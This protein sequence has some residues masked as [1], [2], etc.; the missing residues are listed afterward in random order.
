MPISITFTAESTAEL[1]KAIA[2]FIGATPSKAES[3]PAAAKPAPKAETAPTP[4]PEPEAESTGEVTDADL[5]TAAVS[6]QQK[7]GRDALAAA[8][9]DHGAPAGVTSIPAE[10]R[11]DFVAF[12][13]AE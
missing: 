10:R 12:C 1:H 3:K 13:S 9:K 8:L 11:A 4:A 6:Y 2:E 5:K 7:N